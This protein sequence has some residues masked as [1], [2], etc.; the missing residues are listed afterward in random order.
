[1]TGALSLWLG[2]VAVAQSASLARLHVT[3]DMPMCQRTIHDS[4][5]LILAVG[6]A[7]RDRRAPPQNLSV[8]R[9]VNVVMRRGARQF[10]RPSLGCFTGHDDIPVGV[11]S[12]RRSCTPL[13]MTLSVASSG[14]LRPNSR[15]PRYPSLARIE[16]QRLLPI[17]TNDPDEPLR[18][19]LASMTHPRKV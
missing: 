1:M 14:W 13:W 16:V 12:H 15:Q 7:R 3:T 17:G 10:R 9:T 18:P 2:S 11:L 4:Y 6:G 19:C 8:R 5:M